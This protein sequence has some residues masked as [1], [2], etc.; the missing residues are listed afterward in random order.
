MRYLK[1][2][3]LIGTMQILSM[4]LVQAYCNFEIVGMG[5]SPNELQSK[6]PSIGL[7]EFD[8]APTELKVAVSDICGDPIYQ[9]LFLVYEYIEKK[10]HRIQ[11]SESNSQ[12]AYLDNLIYHY[13]EPQELREV[14]YG[15]NYYYWDLSF[16]EVF[17]NMETARSGE[18]IFAS[19]EI[20]SNSH[21]DLIRKYQTDEE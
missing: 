19:I 14:S 11:L 21:A 12:I 3:I 7:P 13:G 10:L 16:R 2:I 20:T 6:I 15:I 1:I 8:L 4:G 17:F 9:D 18:T 5:T